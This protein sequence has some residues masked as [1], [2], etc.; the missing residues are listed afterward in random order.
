MEAMIY[1]VYGKRD[2]GRWRGLEVRSEQAN[3]LKVDQEEG[4]YSRRNIIKHESDWYARRT[5]RRTNY[6][7][8]EIL[9]KYFMDS[10]E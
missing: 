4:Q 6:R 5:H 2:V 1:E 8:K 7:W 10:F 3:S 9:E